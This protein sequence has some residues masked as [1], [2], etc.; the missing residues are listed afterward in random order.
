MRGQV[1]TLVHPLAT[2]KY[3]RWHRFLVYQEW[4]GSILLVCW[5][6]MCRLSMKGSK[7][8]LA[9]P[10]L[11]LQKQNDLCA[12]NFVH[13]PYFWHEP[14][15]ASCGYAWSPR[16]C[17]ITQIIL[18][19]EGCNT[20][21]MDLCS[22]VIWSNMTWKITPNFCFSGLSNGGKTNS[23]FLISLPAKK[24]HWRARTSALYISQTIPRNHNFKLVYKH[25]LNTYA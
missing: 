3:H 16:L 23:T 11:W 2:A 20:T 17:G 9:P 5:L 18:F 7:R 15:L 8:I 4:P 6:L 24:W 21:K 14:R 12:H 1:S 25:G 19:L 13:S 22:I 10:L